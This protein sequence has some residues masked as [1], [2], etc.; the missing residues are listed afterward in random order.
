MNSW[1]Y[2]VHINEIKNQHD[3]ILQFWLKVN[4]ELNILRKILAF[5]M[6]ITVEIWLLN[7]FLKTLL[8]YTAL[9]KNAIFLQQFFAFGDI[10]PF[11]PADATPHHEPREEVWMNQNLLPFYYSG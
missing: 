4:A 6:K 1:K 7:R 11:S 5:Y 3:K 2:L 8:F 10:F 9:E